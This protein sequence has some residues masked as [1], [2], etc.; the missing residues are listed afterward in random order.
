MFTAD[1]LFVWFAS[2][3]SA[4]AVFLGRLLGKPS[5]VVVGGIDLAKDE[6]SGYGIWL[7]RWKSILVRYAIRNANKILA[8]DESL[9]IS[10]IRLAGYKGD[11][12]EVVPTGY[13]GEFWNPAGHK[14]NLVLCVAVAHDGHR[15]I[16][17]G[18]DALVDAA[19]LLPNVPFVVVGVHPGVAAKFNP[20]PNIA[21]QEPIQR[22]QLLPFYRRARVYCQ[23]SRFEGLPNALCEAMLC[24]CIPVVTNAGGMKRV[25][26]DSGLVAERIDPQILAEN[27]NVALK[28]SDQ[29]GK[30]AR[31]RIQ[32]VY[33][34]TARESALLRLFNR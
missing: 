24:E 13:D 18:V 2:T 17:K 1:I 27:I 12:I 26:G 22:D 25:V 23:P 11:N 34:L 5:F 30:K 28:G 31:A 32:S 10:A 3:Y 15:M 8:V 14:E 20:P 29:L 6:V 21:F 33:T 7:S 16:V 9:K 4:F 19:R